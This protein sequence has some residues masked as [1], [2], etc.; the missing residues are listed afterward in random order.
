MICVVYYPGKEGRE[1][2]LAFMVTTHLLLT[3]LRVHIAVPLE[4]L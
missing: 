2:R 3:S 4:V 1:L